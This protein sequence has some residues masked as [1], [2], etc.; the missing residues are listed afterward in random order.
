MVWLI[1][2]DQWRIKGYIRVCE[3]TKRK[4]C[5]AKLRVQICNKTAGKTMF[6]H[7]FYNVTQSN[8]WLGTYF[9]QIINQQVLTRRMIPS[10]ANLV[11]G[12]RLLFGF[13]HP[14]N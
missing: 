1:T 14:S 5:V 12:T 3:G 8:K 7:M 9:G 2:L 11:E 6:F 13:S 10:L 4:P